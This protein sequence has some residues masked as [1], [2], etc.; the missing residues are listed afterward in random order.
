MRAVQTRLAKL[1]PRNRH[2]LLITFAVASAT[3]A[4]YLFVWFAPALTD[5]SPL[6]SFVSSL[7]WIWI[8]KV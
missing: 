8:D 4:H 3:L 7:A 6:A 5:L 1:S 2:H